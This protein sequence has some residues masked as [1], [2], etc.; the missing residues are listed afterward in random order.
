VRNNVSRREVER[1]RVEREASNPLYR[2]ITITKK[3]S[4]QRVSD[5]QL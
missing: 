1:S 4:P 2:G 5:F 3:S